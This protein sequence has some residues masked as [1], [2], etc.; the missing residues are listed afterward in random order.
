[1]IKINKLTTPH[2][3][4][5]FRILSGSIGGT[6]GYYE[7][8]SNTK[9]ELRV[10]LL[11]ETQYRCAYCMQ[12]LTSRST[13]IEHIKPYS[14]LTKMESIDYS[15]LVINCKTTNI[16]H[17]YLKSCSDHKGNSLLTKVNHLLFSDIENQITYGYNGR[18]ISSDHDVE[19][20]LQT[21]NLNNLNLIENRYKVIVKTIE[22]IAEKNKHS[23]YTSAMKKRYEDYIRNTSFPY[24]GVVIDLF[25]KV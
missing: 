5:R 17:K 4:V 12:P 9:N 25:K 20:D 1:M 24:P 2:K 8:D 23:Q 3:L 6:Q 13:I 10:H 11:E 7:L 16:P 19:Q 15:N 14:L 22:M 21:L 18:I